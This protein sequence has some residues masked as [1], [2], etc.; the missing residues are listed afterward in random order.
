MKTTRE[1]PATA[2]PPEVFHQD[3]ATTITILEHISDAFFILDAAGK[4]QYANRVALD[5]LRIDLSDLIH[6]PI[7]KFLILAEG[8]GEAWVPEP[9][10]DLEA[11]LVNGRRATPVVAGIGVVP[12]LDGSAQYVLVSAKDLS[13]RDRIMAE[14]RRQ[15]EMAVSRDRLKALGGMAMALVHELSQ[16]LASIRLTVEL[17]QKQASDGSITLPQV[18]EECAQIVRTVES[19]TNT[20]QNSRNFAL[21][22]EDESLRLVDLHVSV[23]R[24]LARLAYELQERKVEVEVVSDSYLPA[25]AANP[26]SMEQMMVSLIRILWANG[27]RRLKI[28]LGAH[29]SKWVALRLSDPQSKPDAGE[30]WEV[31]AYDQVPLENSQAGE[32]SAIR[33]IV[34]GLGGDLKVWGKGEMPVTVAIRVPADTADERDQLYNLIEMLHQR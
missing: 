30:P 16:P 19:M 14:E 10:S 4:I 27:S 8:P 18:V 1:K 28:E 32:I 31:T 33:S 25:V 26:V 20:V 9:G 7:G 2:R 15:A 5:L 6:Q 12:N 23:D 22:V 11:H 21:E 34:T 3:Y 29:G 17:L 24:A 13:A